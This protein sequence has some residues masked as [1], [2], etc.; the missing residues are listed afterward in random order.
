MLLIMFQQR[1]EKKAMEAGEKSSMTM[2]K[3]RLLEKAGFIWAKRK[4]QAAW[5]DKFRE[6][7]QFQKEHG[8]CTYYGASLVVR[9]ISLTLDLLLHGAQAMSQPRTRKIEHWVAG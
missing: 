5:E 3:V 1:M 6:L 8:H 4:G 7:Q 9:G 2:E